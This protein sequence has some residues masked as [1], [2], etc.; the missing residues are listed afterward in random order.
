[1]EV[2]VTQLCLILCDPMDCS[3]PGSSVQGISQ[4]RILEWVAI[5][6]SRGSSRPRDQT[7]VSCIVGRFCSTKLPGKPP[8]NEL[9]R[10]STGGLD[11]GGRQ[12]DGAQSVW[13]EGGAVME[14]QCEHVRL[15]EVTASRFRS[16][17]AL[18]EPWQEEALTAHQEHSR[19]CVRNLVITAA[20]SPW[21]PT[22]TR[23]DRRSLR[24]ILS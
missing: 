2:T 23:G 13:R 17:D 22:T 4:A 12:S 3:P 9:R 24:A 14:A 15:R 8:P 21:A 20:G 16:Q 5:S 10:H 7:R 19:L 6:S 18:Q 1:M 11:C